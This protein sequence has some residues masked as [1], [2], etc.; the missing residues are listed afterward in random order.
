MDTSA[1]LGTVGSAVAFIL[2]Q[3]AMLAA[4]PVV[5]PLL[6]LYASRQRE[7][8]ATAADQ[9]A[10]L[11]QLEQLLLQLQAEAADE[12]AAEVG[13]EVEELLAAVQQQQQ[14]GGPPSPEVARLLRGLDG[15]LSAM[16]GSVV[17]TGK[18]GRGGRHAECW[19]AAPARCNGAVRMM[20]AVCLRLRRAPRGPSAAPHPATAALAVQAPPRGKPCSA[21]PRLRASWPAA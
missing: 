10:Q 11:A 20:L 2:T 13:A 1:W 19:A 5:L 18:Q 12:M 17:S 16:E 6:A 9:A 8:L 4:A 15:K 21:A 3:E 7:R 14:R